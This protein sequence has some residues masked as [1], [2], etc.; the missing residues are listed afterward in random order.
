MKRLIAISTLV[1]IFV[2]NAYAPDDQ[3]LKVCVF[4]TEDKD[5]KTEQSIIESH[6]KRELRA[7]GDVVIVDK[8][9][10]WESRIM[11]NILGH[12]YQNGTKAPTLSIAWSI[13]PRIPKRDFNNYE[14]YKWP[15]IPVYDLQGP[16]IGVWKRDILPSYCIQVANEFDKIVD[17]ILKLQSNVTR[18]QNPK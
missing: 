9:D 7:L 8:E 10:D 6:L 16:F 13:Q 15:H 5:N 14:L 1:I 4:V 2:G 18:P 17:I 11:I 3:K 12:K